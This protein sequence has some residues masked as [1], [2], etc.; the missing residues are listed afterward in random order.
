MDEEIEKLVE[1]T[2]NAKN[3]EV[4]SS[5]LRD[6]DNQTDPNTRLEPKSD[7]ESLKVEKTV[8]VQ[9]VNVYEEEEESAEDDYELRRREKRK[10]VEE[11][12]NTPSPKT[13][14]SPSIH[15]TLVS[16]DTEKLQELTVT[17]PPPLSSTPSS[18][19][20]KLSATR[21]LLSL[22]MSRQKFNVL[23]QH[24][25]DIMEESLPKMVDDRVKELKKTQVPL[26][27]AQ[28]LI[29]ERKQSHTDVAKMFADAIQQERENL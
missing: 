13:I 19:S 29:M 3:V 16:S 5:I 24:L 18:S 17:D 14:R 22:F 6:D 10:H 7:K 25:Q 12:R 15:S 23:A 8:E 1:G 21:K 2:E 4:D 20:T 11:I 27:V 9:P 26:Y 28:A